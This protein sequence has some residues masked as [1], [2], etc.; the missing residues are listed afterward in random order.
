MEPARRNEEMVKTAATV[1]QPL[2]AR[3][4]FLQRH[5]GLVVTVVLLVLGA[6]FVLL[7]LYWLLSTAF[8]NGNDAFALPPRYVTK[9]TL[10]N[11]TQILGGQFAHYVLNSVI[12]AVGSTAVALLLGVP[13]GYAFA[14]SPIRGAKVFDTWFV[15]AYVAPPVVFIIPLYIMYQHL[16]LLDTYQGLILAYETGLLPFTIWLMRVYFNEVPRELDEAAWIDGCSKM[17]ALWKVVLP[18]VWPGLTTVGL[19][20]FL[21]SWGEYFGALILTGP[22]TET[23]PVAVEGYI[24]TTFANWSEL[25]AAG[26]VLVVP[27]LLATIVVQRGFVRGLTF[28]AVKQ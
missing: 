2:R 17:R 27:A 21:A 25:A 26:V 11:F 10:S 15:L 12:V 9:P 4:R 13:A 1:N 14:R 19:L 20:V 24:G 16:H 7:P 28:G 8:K 18:T 23:A 6:I 22:H 3:R 5:A